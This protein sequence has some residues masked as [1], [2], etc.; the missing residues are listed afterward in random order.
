[1]MMED[2]D[3][4]IKAEAERMHQQSLEPLRDQ[5]AGLAMQAMI[6]N[7]AMMQSLQSNGY[8]QVAAYAIVAKSAYKLADAMLKSRELHEP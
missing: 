7:Q 4:R 8:D 5:F 3:A 6:S 2:M 1:M